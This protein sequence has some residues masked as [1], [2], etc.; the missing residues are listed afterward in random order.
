VRSVAAP[1]LDGTGRVVG[2]VGNSGLTFTLDPESVQLFGP[3]VRAAARA[4]SAG[5][6]GR[7]PALGVVG[8]TA[9]ERDGGRAAGRA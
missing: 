6:G 9:G 5:L 3:M 1:V 7:A 2:A 8:R 4:V